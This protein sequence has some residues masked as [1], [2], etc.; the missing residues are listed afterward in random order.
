MAR[1][2]KGPF[3]GIV[4]TIRWAVEMTE[5]PLRSKSKS[6]SAHYNIWCVG[7]RVGWVSIAMIPVY[8]G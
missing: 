3:L 7:D 2:V 4:G 8:A 6:L 5:M 1:C